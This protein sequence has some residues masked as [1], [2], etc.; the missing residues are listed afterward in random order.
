M[1]L[2]IPAFRIL[3]QDESAPIGSK[4]IRC[5]MHFELKLDL[6]RK[7]RFVAGGHMTNPPTFSYLFKCCNP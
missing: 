7:A 5:H 6:T 4:F 1:H 2:V 3:D